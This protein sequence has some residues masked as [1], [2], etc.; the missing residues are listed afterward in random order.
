MSLLGTKFTV[1]L[2]E[3]DYLAYQLYATSTNSRMRKA[4]V[5]NW[6]LMSASCFG[7]AYLFYESNSNALAI[8]FLIMTLVLGVFYPKYSTWYYKR[9]FTKHNREVY[10]NRFGTKCEIQFT[11]EAIFCQDQTSETKIST[12][13]IEQVNEIGSHYFLKL[14]SGPSLIIPKAKTLEIDLVK[15]EILLLT[16]KLQVPLNVDLNWRW[17]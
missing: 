4:R 11:D 6:I 16:K 15:S 17:R 7:L 12:S 9:H 5:R 10:K 3:E 13:D 2:D 8:Y 14:K 1:S